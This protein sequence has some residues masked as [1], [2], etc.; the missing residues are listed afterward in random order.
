MPHGNKL[1]ISVGFYCKKRLKKDIVRKREYDR[2]RC[3][4]KDG[5]K[6]K[7][8]DYVVCHSHFCCMMAERKEVSGWLPKQ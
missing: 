3:E 8:K 7:M 2:E 4:F 6:I 5:G 1:D